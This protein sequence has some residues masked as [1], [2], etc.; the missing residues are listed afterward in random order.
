[1]RADAILRFD[2][3]RTFQVRQK[4]FHGR[5]ATEVNATQSQDKSCD[6]SI[7]R[8]HTIKIT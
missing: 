4:K 6:K 3:Y 1:M 5:D 8:Y 2:S 7:L